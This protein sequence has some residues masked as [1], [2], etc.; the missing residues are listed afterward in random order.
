[1][2]RR[3]KP[4]ISVPWRCEALFEL[5]ALGHHVKSAN[6]E[7]MGGFQAI[8]LQPDPTASVL[9]GP[10]GDAPIRVVYRAASDDRKDGEAVGW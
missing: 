6:D 5:R 2:N 7:N 1:M 10:G 8:L 3:R 9:A 4:P